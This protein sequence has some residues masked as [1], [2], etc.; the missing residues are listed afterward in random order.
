ML[1]QKVGKTD[2][3]IHWRADIVAHVKK[4]FRFCLIR[5]SCLF[6]CL[7]QLIDI[8]LFPIFFAVK[9]IK[10]SSSHYGENQRKNACNYPPDSRNPS[11][12]RGNIHIPGI[13]RNPTFNG[14]AILGTSF[15]LF[16]RR[17][18]I[19]PF[20]VTPFRIVFLQDKSYLFIYDGSLFT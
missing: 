18:C 13:V 9:L 12:S 6:G 11:G 8:L 15:W 17:C 10:N 5:K 16:L 3:C 1:F 14:K 19:Y 20:R 4:K 2:D 7:L